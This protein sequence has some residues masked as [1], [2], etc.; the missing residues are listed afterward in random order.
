MV[1]PL[2]RLGRRIRALPRLLFGIIAAGI[3]LRVAWIAYVNVDPFDG[4]IDDTVFYFASAQWLAE[5]GAYRDQFGR[6]SAH[7]PPGYSAVLSTA[8][9]IF[10]AT[11]ITAK[12][13]NVALAAAACALTYALGAR[14]FGRREGLLASAVLALCPGQIYFATLVMT[15]VFFGFL[16]LSFVAL[17]AWWTLADAEASSLKLIAL[18]VLAGAA[19]LTRAEALIFAATLPPLWLLAQPRWRRPLRYGAAFTA[20][21]VLAVAPWTVRNAV[22]FDDFIPIRSGSGGALS[23]ALDPNY[24]NREGG[25]LGQA[26]PLRETAGHMLRHPWELAP[27]ELDKLGDLYG[28]DRDGVA[29]ILHERPPIGPEAA[30]R[31]ATLANLYFFVVLAVAVSGAAFVFRRHDRWHVAIAWGVLGWTAAEIV[32][33][34]ESRYHFPVV[35]LLAILAAAAAARAW[36]RVRLLEDATAPA[37][38][39]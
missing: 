19:V 23:S 29:W 21:V 31:W 8:F 36:D 14:A 2:N 12:A 10:G 4:R 27:L 15:E 35:P 25:I 26:P 32:F 20:G 6:F 17:V 5:D 38:N 3:A 16:F 37:G 33:W 24:R 13:L 34:P 9:A 30:D 1:A 11:L 28:N 39:V 18:G 7:W 22:R